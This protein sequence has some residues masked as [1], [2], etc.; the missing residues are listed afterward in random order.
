MTNI[1]FLHTVAIDPQKGGI[2][3]VTHTLSHEL[4]KRGHNV[5][6]I[7]MMDVYRESCDREHQ[8]FFPD[9]KIYSK[10][11]ETFLKNFLQKKRINI[12]IFQAGDD[13]L[14]PFPHI[15]KE[16]QIRLIVAIHTDPEFY[17]ALVR[18]KFILKYG[19]S[20]AN[21]CSWIIAIKTLLRKK[22]Q[23]N[24]YRKN[25]RVADSVVLLSSKFIEPFHRYLHIQDK[26]KVRAIPNPIERSNTHVEEI[27]K[28]QEILYV[29]R[30]N[31]GEKRVDLLLQIWAIIQDEFPEW[32]L[33]LIGGGSDE[34][35]LKKLASELALKRISFEGYQ[36][37]EP[38]YR[39]ASIFCL[40]SAFEGFPMVL[41]ESSLHR[42]VPIAFNSSAGL[43]D[44]ISHG[45]NGMLVPP[46]NMEKYAN[47]LRTLIHDEPK[48]RSLSHAA[49]E[50]AQ[51]FSLGR[52]IP[53][54]ESILSQ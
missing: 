16:L 13:K 32:S 12:V 42:C 24:I 53:L 54:W 52:I 7:S 11:N 25:A 29:G 39:R 23:K 8:I 31:L 18:S 10:E 3:K 48:R 37:P 47:T 4:R 45:V 9:K 27:H 2:E 35:K 46:S 5:D 26:D 34:D 43:E 19:K 21:R 14:V 22:K 30:M 28:K 6:Y 17:K 36:N 20:I 38:Y 1:A 15:F 41:V 44:I 40:T 50:N 49:H 51:R 33:C